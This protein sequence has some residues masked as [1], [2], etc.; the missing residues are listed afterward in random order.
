MGKAFATVFLLVFWLLVPSLA[1][2]QPAPEAPKRNPEAKLPAR[3]EKGPGS[4][5]YAH[6]SVT[7]ASNGEGAERYWVYTPAEP[8]P[9]E[10]PVVCFVHGFG[11]LQ[12][13][14]Y[15]GWLNHIA[16]RGHI[17]IYPQYQASALEPP[18]NYAPNSAKAVVAAIAWLKE[19]ESRVQPVEKDFALVGHSAGGVTAANMAADWE[20]LNLPKPRVLKSVQPGRAFS[21]AS[22]AQKDGLIPLSDFKKIPED[23]LLLSLYSDSDR[24]VGH[25]CARKIFADAGSKA[26]NRNLVEVRSCTC[27]AHPIIAH[28]QTPAAPESADDVL[29]WY[30]YWKLFDGLC[31]AAFRGKHRE[32]AL[33]DTEKQRFMGK[34]SD[35]REVTPLKITLGSAEVDPDVAYRPLYRNDGTPYVDRG[36]PVPAPRA[37]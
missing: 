11:A 26:E 12:P 31:D 6:K 20:A 15:A 19:D 29:D 10:A 24:T 5:D 28:H 1:Q 3:P 36:A 27:G 4:A 17:V 35:G 16:R 14:P 13:T 37:E 9:K 32:Y 25:W 23:C 2:E 18:E 30:A 7:V 22:E 34:Y 8:A 33:G 21:Y